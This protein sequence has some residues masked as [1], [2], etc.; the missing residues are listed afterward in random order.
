MPLTTPKLDDLTFQQIVDHAKRLI[1]LYCPEWTDHNVSDPG[2]TL[3]ELFASMMELLLYRVNRVPDKVYLTFLNFIGA[4]LEPPQPAQAR[5]T[6]YLTRKVLAEEQLPAGLEVSTAR[7]E[8]QEP[9]VFVTRDPLTL[10]PARLVAAYR[11]GATVTAGVEPVSAEAAVWDEIDLVRLRVEQ[12]PTPVFP[13]S[14]IPGNA[15]DLAFDSDLSD[16]VLA[17]ECGCV[18]AGGGGT[19]LLDPP[20]EWQAWQPDT[21][22]W[23]RCGRDL[24]ETAGFNRSGRMLLRVPALQIGARHGREAF[25][26]RCV[27]NQGQ[28]PDRPYRYEGM[29]QLTMLEAET[30]GVTGTAWQEIKVAGETLGESNGMPGQHFRLRHFPVLERDSRHERLE[31]HWPDERTKEIWEERPDFSTAEADSPVYTLDSHDGTLTLGPLLR[32]PEGE[33]QRLGRVPPRGARLVFSAY[34]YGGGVA[35]NV[36][37]NTITVLKTSPSW[38]GRVNNAERAHGGRDGQTIADLQRVPPS[39][40]GLRARAVTADDYEHL[41]ARVPGVARARCLA[42]GRR[43]HGGREPAADEPGARLVTVLVVPE[44]ASDGAPLVEEL[45]LPGGA[46]L[47]R[48]VWRD[49]DARAPLGVELLVQ[50][51]G[52]VWVAVDAVVRI[53]PGTPEA[54]RREVERQAVAALERYLSPQQGGPDGAGWPFGRGLEHWELQAVLRQVPGVAAVESAQMA[55]VR[56]DQREVPERQRIPIRSIELKRHELISSWRHAV[57]A[58]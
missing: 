14:L 19:S 16:Q 8:T 42:P 46:P 25:W 58:L 7:T 44:P 43:E 48:A 6:F 31:I 41:A 50:A 17:L 40:L 49:L 21:G 4:Q 5:V 57:R 56:R 15:L 37:A 28:L 13:A 53:L 55:V 30:R 20:I 2:V 18:E 51:P 39:V 32:Q 36:G 24:D 22:R 38:V 52:Y 54:R 26:I 29:P 10:R 47:L 3:I 35:G 23:V 11:V 9:I 33:V 34:R 45:E 12:Q 27:L 1:P